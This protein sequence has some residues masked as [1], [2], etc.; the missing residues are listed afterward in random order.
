MALRAKNYQIHLP[1]C[2]SCN[3]E[4]WRSMQRMYRQG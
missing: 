4:P 2:W 1:E 3:K